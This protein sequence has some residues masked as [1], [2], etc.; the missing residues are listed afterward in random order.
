MTDIINEKWSFREGSWHGLIDSDSEPAILEADLYEHG[1]S[2]REMRERERSLME[3]IVDLHNFVRD[4]GGLD[5]VKNALN[6]MNRRMVVQTLA[7][8]KGEAEKLQADLD[9]ALGAIDEVMSHDKG[10]GEEDW[11]EFCNDLLPFMKSHGL[12]Q[13]TEGWS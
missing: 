3:Y 10:M 11:I 2:E 5:T 6:L 9:T 1:G 4:N 7:Q 13:Y 8:W 12:R